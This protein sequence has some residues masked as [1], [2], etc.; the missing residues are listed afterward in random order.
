MQDHRSA[1]AVP[2]SN[3]TQENKGDLIAFPAT[4]SFSLAEANS[5]VDI[6]IQADQL[7]SYI[8]KLTSLADRACSTAIRQSETTHLIEENRHSEMMNL[9]HRLDQQSAQL[10]EQQ[11][12]LVRLDHESKAQI[13]S[14]ETQ[15]QGTRL[16]RNEENELEVLRSENAALISRLGEAEELARQAQARIQ[17]DL[18]PLQEEVAELRLQLARR[19]ET[20]HTKQSAIKNHELDFR[21]KILELKQSL[22]DAQTEIQNQETKLKDKEALIQATAVKEMEMGNLIKRLSDECAMLSKELQEKNQILPRLEPKKASSGDAKIWRRVIGR[23]QEEP[24]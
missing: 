8:N 3:K 5:I 13:A 20:I 21:A 23:L 9:R 10:H 4:P 2:P 1:R 12:A 22:R 11:L 19:D 24:Q 6:E 16:H 14:L 15:L 17:E 18:A 7:L